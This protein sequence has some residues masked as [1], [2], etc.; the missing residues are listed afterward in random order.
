[1]SLRPDISITSQP[2]A[3]PLSAR[4]GSIQGDLGFIL[5]GKLT[6]T[7]REKE[8]IIVNGANFYC[9]EIEDVVNQIEGVE[10]TFVASCGVS[11]PMTGTEGLAIFFSPQIDG[12]EE[13]IGLIQT[14]RARVTA[15]LGIS[16]FAVVPVQ[17]DAFPK[18]TSGKIQRTKLKGLLEAG[19]FDQVL[20]TID[21]HLENARTIPDWFFQ[22]RWR[23]SE[24]STLKAR[25]STPVDLVLGDGS[26]VVTELIAKAFTFG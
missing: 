13:N 4:A 6:L 24:R 25:P 3:T 17:R 9:Y 8:I 2:I 1:M 26:G 22:P 10:P 18:T 11:D 5:D 21:L 19:H 20:K 16:P 15:S 14:I 7:G 12:L 23:R